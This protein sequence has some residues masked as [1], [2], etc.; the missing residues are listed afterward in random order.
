MYTSTTATCTSYALTCPSSGLA[1]VFIVIYVLIALCCAFLPC[2]IILVLVFCFGCT[3]VGVLTCGKKGRRRDYQ[4]INV[5]NS[6]PG[7]VAPPPGAYYGV[8][9]KTQGYNQYPVQDNY[10]P[11]P[12]YNY[13]NQMPGYSVPVY[14]QESQPMDQKPIV[15]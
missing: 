1:A 13:N 2:I 8:D 5:N 6:N 14:S 3:L 12:N 11:A 10:N 4:P 7:Y 9:P 15:Y